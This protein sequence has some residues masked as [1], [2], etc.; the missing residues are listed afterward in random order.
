MTVD[1]VM[2]QAQ[3]F[4]SAWSLIGGQFDDGTMHEEALEA[5]K[6]LRD[7]V[8]SVVDSNVKPLEPDWKSIAISLGQRV[9]F[10]VQSC[11]CKG[12][13]MLNME[14]GTVTGWREQKPV[15]YRAWFDKDNGARWLFTLWPEEE[16]LDVDW[17]PLFTAPKA[18]I[19][20]ATATQKP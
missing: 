2:E 19:P 1:K 3:V 16:R 14:T 4:A 20:S 11:D 9:N 6:E 7:L 18:T 8:Q 13:G 12:G 17:E 15:A 10:A 5:K